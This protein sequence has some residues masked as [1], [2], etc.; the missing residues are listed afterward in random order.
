MELVSDFDLRERRWL[1]LIPLDFLRIIDLFAVCTTGSSSRYSWLLR[2]DAP[3]L[4]R[5]TLSL[6]IRTACTDFLFSSVIDTI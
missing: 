6:E 4:L 3:Q 2:I 1:E 5:C